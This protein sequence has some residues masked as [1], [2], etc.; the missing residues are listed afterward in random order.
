VNAT[1]SRPAIA[2]NQVMAMMLRRALPVS[3]AARL[4]T[5]AM[6]RRSDRLPAAAALISGS[7]GM[8]EVA[9]QEQRLG[10]RQAHPGDGAEFTVG[11]A[12]AKQLR[13][14]M[15]DIGTV[16]NPKALLDEG[17]E[18]RALG[19]LRQCSGKAQRCAVGL[20]EQQ[21]QGNLPIDTGHWRYASQVKLGGVSRA[22]LNE[23]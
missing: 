15:T 7:I 2:S 21:G 13:H 9:L 11:L 22:F 20:A 10:A 6:A 5:S 18:G 1:H 23:V 14:E 8:V 12:D 3:L 16:G 4:P 19:V 17:F